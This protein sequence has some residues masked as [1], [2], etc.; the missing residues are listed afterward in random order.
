MQTKENYSDK[1]KREGK[2]WSNKEKKTD[3]KEMGKNVGKT[4]AWKIREKSKF[5][6]QTHWGKSPIFVQKLNFHENLPT[7]QFEFSR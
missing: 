6:Y 2:N 7:H 3:K 5:T 4:E 1:V